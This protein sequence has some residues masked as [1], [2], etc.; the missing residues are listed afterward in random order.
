MKKTTQIILVLIAFVLGNVNVS[1][2]AFPIQQHQQSEPTGSMVVVEN[3]KPVTEIKAKQLSKKQIKKA[4]KKGDS[5][6][7]KGLYVILSIIGLGW[8][9]MG[10]LDDFEGS[11]WI[12]S[13]VLSLLFWLPG[14]IYSFIK[15]KKYFS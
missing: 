11:D 5:G 7:S 13:L 12:I 9:A 2:A 15:M 14:V 1:Y 10:I 6:I 8:L 4:L 3:A